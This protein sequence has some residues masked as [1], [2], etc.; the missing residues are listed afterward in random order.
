MTLVNHMPS[1]LSLIAGISEWY[2]KADDVSYWIAERAELD[3][4]H[5]MTN[6]DLN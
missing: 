2:L 6:D 3:L 4:W 5:G 1:R